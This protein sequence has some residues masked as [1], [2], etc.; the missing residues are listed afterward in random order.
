MPAGLASEN[1]LDG[2]S[3]VS[4]NLLLD[5]TGLIDDVFSREEFTI[6]IMKV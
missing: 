3:M 4:P 1:D 6:K 5:I 2:M